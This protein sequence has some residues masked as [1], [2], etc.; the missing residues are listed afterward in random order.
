MIYSCSVVVL[1]VYDSDSYYGLH[2]KYETR[3]ATIYM[4]VAVRALPRRDVALSTAQ[5]S[6][7]HMWTW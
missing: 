1:A 2:V 3:L 7:C 4:L 5:T 6:E